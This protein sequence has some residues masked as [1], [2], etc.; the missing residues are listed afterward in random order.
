[1]PELHDLDPE[2]KL[3]FLDQMV[4]FEAVARAFGAEDE[5]RTARRGDAHLLASLPH[6]ARRLWGPGHQG[7]P[8]LV[9]ALEMTGQESVPWGQAI[10]MRQALLG[11]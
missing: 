1:M 4:R 3:S 8:R 2:T 10:Q 5:C 9:G 7:R 6:V 11:L